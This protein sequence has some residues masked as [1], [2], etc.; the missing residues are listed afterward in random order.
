MFMK[1]G[2]FSFNSKHARNA[3][4][5]SGLGEILSA[6]AWAHLS[7]KLRKATCLR[8]ELSHGQNLCEEAASLRH[9]QTLRCVS[10]KSQSISQREKWVLEVL[11][12]WGGHHRYLRNGV[13]CPAKWSWVEVP[14]SFN[15]SQLC[16]TW[17]PCA[18]SFNFSSL[19]FLKDHGNNWE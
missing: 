13:G 9:Y 4:S 12:F 14:E 17:W 10:G 16:S 7:F 15:P 5:L 18:K 2:K 8:A 6:P 3:F 1:N 19:R 11:T